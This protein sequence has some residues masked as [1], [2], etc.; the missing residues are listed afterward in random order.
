MRGFDTI[1]RAR[2]TLDLHLGQDNDMCCLVTKKRLIT[3]TAVILNTTAAFQVSISHEIM[4][5]SNKKRVTANATNL[6]TNS[7]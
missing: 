6:I 1:P 5:S 2:D 7:R 3:D 4:N